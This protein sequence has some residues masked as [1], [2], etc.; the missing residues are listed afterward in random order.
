[1]I[2]N[3]LK[4]DSIKT[5]DIS[6]GFNKSFLFSPLKSIQITVNIIKDPLLGDIDDSGVIDLKESFFISLALSIDAICAG[7]ALYMLHIYSIILPLVFVLS[8]ILLLNIGLFIGKKIAKLVSFN[9]SKINILPG[10][11]F[12]VIAL[13]K[14]IYSL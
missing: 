7:F 14:L 10:V 1:M 9:I 4:K 8:Q 12:I 13:L 2:K 3:A 6:K 5:I 11:V